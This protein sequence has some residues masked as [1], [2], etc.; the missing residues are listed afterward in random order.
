MPFINVKTNS[1]VSKEKETA[2]KS[3]LGEAITTLPG[4]SESWLMVGI[5]PE[6]ILYFK[7][8]DELCAM[9]DVSIF[10]TATPA[11]LSALTAKITEILSSELNIPPARTYVK[12]SQ[13][14]EWG[15]NG[16]N[17]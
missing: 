13:K 8:T 10:G 12:Y 3:K 14:T 6:Y 15:W 5:E 2:I 1:P 17:L 7:G 4:K 16:S 11:A 9:V